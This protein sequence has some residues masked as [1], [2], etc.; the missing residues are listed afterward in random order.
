MLNSWPYGILSNHTVKR[1]ASQLGG[2]NPFPVTTQ[3]KDP[4]VKELARLGISTTP[5]PATVKLRGKQ[6]PLTATE[7]SQLA[8]TEGKLLHD[9]VQKWLTTK[10]WAALDDDGR[11]KKIAELRKDISASRAQRLTKIRNTAFGAQVNARRDARR[12][13]AAD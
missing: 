9:R 7:K 10:G 3:S 13:A 8:E 6:S 11:R 4:V 12:E 2:A 5:V 1:P